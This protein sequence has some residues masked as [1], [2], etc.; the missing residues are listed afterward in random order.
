MKRKFC[1]CMHMYISHFLSAGH[2]YLFDRL[3]I[4]HYIFIEIHYNYIRY[5]QCSSVYF[6]PQNYEIAQRHTDMN[7]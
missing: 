7:Q 3:K 1:Q 4:I 5:L 2:N 6:R